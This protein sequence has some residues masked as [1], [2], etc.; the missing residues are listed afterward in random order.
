MNKKLTTILL[1]LVLLVGCLFTFASCQN[2]TEIDIERAILGIDITLEYVTDKHGLQHAENWIVKYYVDPA[3]F[4]LSTANRLKLRTYLAT[5]IPA[6]IFTPKI[7]DDV[8]PTAENNYFVV[9]MDYDKYNPTKKKEWSHQISGY[10]DNFVTD[11]NGIKHYYPSEHLVMIS[12][13][14]YVFEDIGAEPGQNTIPS[15]G[16]TIGVGIG[17]V[18]IGLI[19]YI[20]AL[21]LNRQIFVAIAFL[22]PILA[23]IGSYIAWGVGRG[24]IM[25]VFFGIYYAGLAVI[26]KWIGDRIS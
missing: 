6:K 24:I 22:I 21:I 14:A 20:I 4:D 13:Y 12:C 19:T 2:E 26:N 3:L 17:M 10:I 18:V 7:P 8:A 15:I 1:I 5:D 9:E 23:T 16:N 11:E 25:T